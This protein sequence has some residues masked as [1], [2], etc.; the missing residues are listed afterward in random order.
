MARTYLSML[1]PRRRWGIAAAAATLCLAI[2]AGA[3][4]PWTFGSVEKL[5]ADGWLDRI[6]TLSGAPQVFRWTALP[7]SPGAPAVGAMRFWVAGL[8]LDL[9]WPLLVLL[10]VR[11]LAVGAA[12]RRARTS[13]FVGTWGAV[14]LSAA[15]AA[16]AAAAVY[17]NPRGAAMRTS[18]AM[19]PLDDYTT[20]DVITMTALSAVAIGLAV[21]WLPALAAAALYRSRP[22]GETDAEPATAT[23]S[24]AA[25]TAGSDFPEFSFNGTGYEPTATLPAGASPETL[26]LDALEQLRMARRRNLGGPLPDAAGSPFFEEEEPSSGRVRRGVPTSYR[27]GFYNS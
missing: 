16:A 24:A 9:G 1:P 26:D 25:S 19:V 23:P 10:A 22:V 21:G 2:A 18:L 15:L 5:P 20:G 12:P 3:G 8:V 27:P 7:H 4:N 17:G 13:L 11:L 14:A 6:P